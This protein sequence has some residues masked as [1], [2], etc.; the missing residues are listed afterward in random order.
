[1]NT[2]GRLQ[3]KKSIISDIV[4][5]RS[6]TY[7]THPISDIRFSDIFFLKPRPTLPHVLVT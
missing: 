2:K 6:Q 4:T 3:K 1:M 7:P 5:I